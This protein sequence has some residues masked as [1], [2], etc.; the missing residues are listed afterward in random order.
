MRRVWAFLLLLVPVHAALAA[1]ADQSCAL[2]PRAVLNLQETATGNVATTMTSE[3]HEF[4][5]IIDTG[6]IYSAI[7]EEAAQLLG[8]TPMLGNTRFTAPGGV[9]MDRYVILNDVTLGGLHASKMA[10]SV[11][12]QRALLGVDGLLGPTVLASYDADFDFAANKLTLFD[13]H[14]CPGQVVYW[15]TTYGAVPMK[16]EPNLQIEAEVTLD[17]KTL[18]A[19]IDTGATR[20]T[21]AAATAKDL[22]GLGTD[23]PGAAVQGEVLNGVVVPVFRGR[24]DRLAFGDVAVENPRINIINDE[25]FSHSP[26]K[27]LIGMDVLRKLHLYI[28][29]G[30]RTLYV[31]GAG[32]KPDAPSQSEP[33]KKS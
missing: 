4:H 17:G 7:T 26:A 3:G 32:A 27:L 15:S 8:H 5:L 9:V 1:D 20:S 19:I 12:P 13:Q 14:H 6:A 2:V 23:A 28:A 18:N 11:I 25:N 30:E 33:A 16:V 31:T 10:M 21:M 24:F 29:Y 22:F